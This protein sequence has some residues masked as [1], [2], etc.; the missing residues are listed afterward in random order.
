MSE[1]GWEGI[2]C[3][4]IYNQLL[5]WNLINL[6]R[7]MNLPELL[8]GIVYNS[9]FLISPESL[10]SVSSICFMNSWKMSSRDEWSCLASYISLVT[11]GML[12]VSYAAGRRRRAQGDMGDSSC[13]LPA[14]GCHSGHLTF[15]LNAT[16]SCP[17][18]VLILQGWWM[19]LW[20]SMECVLNS[21]FLL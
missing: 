17:S 9:F 13:G 16:I 6:G 7:Y 20:P 19:L 4:L 15:F 18:P 8:I 3:Q 21:P 5:K 2:F 12:I 10:P 11:G 1:S 14:M